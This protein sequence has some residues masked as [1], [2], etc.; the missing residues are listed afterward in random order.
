M[1]NNQFHVWNSS[2]PLFSSFLGQNPAAEMVVEKTSGGKEHR[3]IFHLSLLCAIFLCLPNMDL[4]FLILLVQMLFWNF[5]DRCILSICFANVAYTGDNVKFLLM[6]T[7][8]LRVF[9]IL[10][11]VFCKTDSIR[12]N[13]GINPPCI[14][15]PVYSFHFR[16]VRQFWL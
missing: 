5:N 1:R 15:C 10:Y 7:W 4:T 14:I 12:R 2:Q 6:R 8:G 16:Y 11:F 9:L 3:G 13:K